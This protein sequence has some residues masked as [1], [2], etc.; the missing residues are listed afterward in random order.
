[1]CYVKKTPDPFVFFVLPDNGVGE[2][3]ALAKSHD[4]K[5]RVRGTVVPKIGHNS[6]RLTPHCQ[7]MLERLVA[8]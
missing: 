2:M 7:Q 5:P 6:H 3:N 4:E 8:E 1:V